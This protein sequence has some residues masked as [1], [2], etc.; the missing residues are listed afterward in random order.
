MSRQTDDYKH[1]SSYIRNPIYSGKSHVS[2]HNLCREDTQCYKSLQGFWQ[3]V[4]SSFEKVQFQ[5]DCCW[6][7]NQKKRGG[8]NG[9]IQ[10]LGVILFSLTSYE[11]GLIQWFYLPAWKL[12]KK[13]WLFLVYVHCGSFPS[14]AIVIMC[15]AM[16]WKFW[17]LNN[18]MI[19]KIF[20]RPFFPPRH[21]WVVRETGHRTCPVCCQRGSLASGRGSQGN[22]HAG[23][24]AAVTDTHPQTRTHT[25][26][27]TNNLCFG[28]HLSPV[29]W[30]LQ[31]NIKKQAHVDRHGL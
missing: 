8:K 1:E 3:T 26:V 31:G 11:R 18:S 15:V 13:P 20:P 5:S 16:L 30:P 23:A 29:L 25:K 9:V 28:F 6:I 2:V 14:L 17:N 24:M 4:L 10:Y 22:S 21:S 27:Q 7:E 19:R 12:C